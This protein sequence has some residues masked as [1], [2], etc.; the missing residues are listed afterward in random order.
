MFAK[1]REEIAAEKSAG[2]T[3]GKDFVLLNLLCELFYNAF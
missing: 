2:A 3:F 1:R